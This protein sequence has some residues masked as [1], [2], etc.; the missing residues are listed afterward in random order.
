MI[1]CDW[2]GIINDYNGRLIGYMNVFFLVML[3]INIYYLCKEWYIKIIKV[4]VILVIFR[5]KKKK[6]FW[7]IRMIVR[8]LFYNE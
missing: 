6:N 3:M 5:K 1:V 8:E 7:S 2:I 4:L